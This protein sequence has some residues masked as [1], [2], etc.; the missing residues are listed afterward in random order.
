MNERAGKGRR[1]KRRVRDGMLG[2]GRRIV[3]DKGKRRWK[4]VH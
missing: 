3:M 4:R 2:M 1:W